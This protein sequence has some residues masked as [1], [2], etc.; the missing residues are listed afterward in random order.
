MF[1]YNNFTKLVNDISGQFAKENTSNFTNADTEFSG[2]FFNSFIQNIN[3]ESSS[4]FSNNNPNSFNYLAIR[5]YSPS[6]SFKALVRFYLPGRYDFG[7]ISLKD[8][9]NEVVTLQS[10]TNVNSDYLTVLGLFTSSFTVSK[11]FGGTGLSGFSG[12]TITTTTFGDFLKQYKNIYGAIISNA[13]PISSIT[14]TV[15]QGQRALVTGDLQ[16]II[17]SYVANRERVYDPLEFSLPFS[18]IAQDSNRT[19]EEYSIGYNLGFTQADTPF[20]TIQR[21]GSFFKILD[22]Y[23]YMKMN[24]EY[25]MNRLDISRQENY[26]QTRD[27]Q[28]ES[29]L[30]NCKLILNN[31]G[32]PATTLIQNPVMFNPP[33]GKLDKLTFTWYDIT[34]A[35]IDNSDCEWSGSIQIVETMDVATIDSTIPKI[36]TTIPKI[37]SRTESANLR[38]DSTNPKT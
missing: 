13:P 18:T 14:G 15:L 25:N 1:Y 11:V 32:S 24:E 9:S 3:L 22:D 38:T 34:G 37:D 33:I 26:A 6:E 8:I 23:I 35:I 10:N 4:N 20:N 2:Y 17:P 5:A 7:Y 21:A 36:D 27:A 29:Q 16:Y 12:S 30:Y 28:A 31:F 19:I